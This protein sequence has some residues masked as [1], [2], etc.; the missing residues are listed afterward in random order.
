MR[1]K[2]KR[3]FVLMLVVLIA[4][5]SVI[6]N[7][8]LMTD[9]E[10]VYAAEDSLKEDFEY[11]GG[12]I[13][14]YIGNDAIVKIP[15]GFSKIGDYAF[16]GCDS[17]VAVD[18]PEGVSVL[19]YGAFED[20]SSLNYV[21]IPQS[22]SIMWH[23]AFSGSWNISDIYYGGS[24]DTWSYISIY[25]GTR[26]S[27]L[28]GA[29]RHYNCFEIPE[30]MIKSIGN[31]V[32]IN[33]KTDGKIYTK[34]GYNA[35]VTNDGDLYMW[36][37]YGDYLNLQEGSKRT[38]DLGRPNRVLSNV[39]EFAIGQNTNFFGAL[40]NDND[41]Y[42]WG[43]NWDGELGNGTNDYNLKPHKILSDVK[44]FSLGGTHSAAVTL[45]GDL[46]VWGDNGFCQLG[47]GT[48]ENRYIP[49]KIMENVETVS[50]GIYHS[51]AIKTNG[52]LY[53]WGYNNHGQVGNGEEYNC[54][55]A[56]TKVLEKVKSIDLSDE[57]SCAITK[58][59][60]LYLWG[61]C[62]ESG[63]GSSIKK[64]RKVMDNISYACLSDDWYNACAAINGNGQLFVWDGTTG[65]YNTKDE[66][67]VGTPKKPL[68]DV[69]YVDISNNNILAVGNDGSLFAWGKN[70]DG[71]VGNGTT[72]IQEI[73]IK[74]FQNVRT[75]NIS[76]DACGL[77]TNDNLVYMWGYNKYGN[78]GDGTTINRLEPTL[79]QYAPNQENGNMTDDA[80]T[81]VR[82][83]A[84]KESHFYGAET[85][86]LTKDGE[87]QDAA[88]EFKNELENYLKSFEDEAKK[89]L[90]GEDEIVDLEKL[91]KIL[92]EEDEKTTDRYITMNDSSVPS[93]ALDSVYYTLASF[94]SST[95]NKTV[96]LGDIDFS[97][98]SITNAMK[99]VRAVRSGMSGGK[100]TKKYGDYEVTF[101]TLNMWASF[102]GSVSVTGK[103][104]TYDGVITS[105]VDGT[106]KVLCAYFDELSDIAK[107]AGKY[108]LFSILSEYKDVT[109]ISSFSKE[110]IK[111]FMYD[112]ASAL[113]KN[114]YGDTLSA[115][116]NIHEG[117]LAVKPVI[118]A[119]KGTRLIAAL[120]NSENIYD[121]I[122]DMDFSDKGVKKKAIKKSLNAVE[123]ARKKLEIKLFNKIYDANEEYT[124]EGF[125]DK[126]YNFFGIRCPVDFEVY[127]N[128]GKLI[129]YVDSSDNH[130]EYI[131]YS[132][133]IYIEVLDDVKSLYVPENK[134]VQIKF[135]ATDNG[136]MNYTIER[137]NSGEK[138]GRL[139]YYNVPLKAGGEYLQTIP[140]SVDLNVNKKELVLE[141]GATK[142]VADEF[143]S[144]TDEKAFVTVSVEASEGGIVLGDGQYPKGDSVELNALIEDD[145]YTFEG[146]YNGDVLLSSNEFYRFTAVGDI[147]LTAKFKE[148][149]E[150][151][152]DYN[153][154]Y[155][156]EYS[157]TFVDIFMRNG[158]NEVFI[159]AN[160]SK[161]SKL[162]TIK[163][164]G[165]SSDG[166]NTYTEEKNSISYENGKLFKG[167]DYFKYEKIEIYD[168]S[169]NL[170]VTIE[171][172]DYNKIVQGLL[173]DENELKLKVGDTQQL[174][175]ILVP[176]IAEKK[177]IDW[178]SNDV[179][180]VEVDNVGMLSALKEGATT[181][182]ATLHDDTSIV[183][184]CNVIIEKNSADSDDA[185]SESGDTTGENRGDSDSSNDS[186]KTNPDESQTEY[187]TK[188][189][190][191]PAKVTLKKNSYV[192]DGKSQKPTV[193]VK[194]NNKTL[195]LGKDYNL[196]YKNIKN[197]G[198]ATVTIIGIGNY[199]GNISKNF[200]ISIKDGTNITSDSCKYKIYNDKTATLTSVGENLENVTIPN[201][202]KL[203]NMGFRVRKVAGNVLKDCK[204][205]K[206]IT[207][208]ET[209]IKL[210]KDS[211]TDTSKVAVYILKG[212][213]KYR[214]DKFRLDGTGSVAVN[215]PRDK[216]ISSA[217]IP[218]TVRIAGVKFKITIIS[219]YA[220][221]KCS[222][223]KKVTLGNNVSVL[224]E[225]SFASCKALTKVTIGTNLSKIN[226]SAFNGD[227]SL[228]TI[229]IKSTRLKTVGG[230]SF[231]GINGKAV[232]KVPSSKLKQYKKLLKGKGQGSGVKIV[233]L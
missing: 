203:G 23:G 71:Q 232:I 204:K 60:E 15:S 176:A 42:M 94:L 82:Q 74:I 39:K 54:I 2:K 143:L 217:N 142:L 206:T 158:E 34:S 177:Q 211:F 31:K 213:Y 131:F 132:D 166:T 228:T 21:R 105:T 134:K 231:K 223:L 147:S 136:V 202:I 199:T 172:E 152:G 188:T 95:V 229:S 58:S 179:K 48:N 24:E 170:I 210:E 205:L 163:V 198:T 32:Y 97:K 122:K 53:L 137:V 12:T 79:I 17:L 155:S 128:N 218:S 197:P 106:Q 20:C 224:G 226:K 85:Y 107:D 126:V 173:L 175:A 3:I 77:V 25:S 145:K 149:V 18:I 222:K 84:G 194:L 141:N 101:D 19:G 169:F 56:P 124:E 139:N 78:L 14:K 36:G 103:G 215:S 150:S 221:R 123:K 190:I 153:I 156:E 121:T 180:I 130:D 10:K 109:G 8:Y 9:M 28:E 182:T 186:V 90:G 49:T 181:V 41:L 89:Q 35:T 26:R 113:Q 65:P 189:N 55:S 168:T 33:F 81:T 184:I 225:S 30:N 110:T 216:N 111:D 227:S 207:L 100:Y 108:A 73:P 102:E 167:F 165:Y 171:K 46:Y 118:Q 154:T 91:G 83:I 157:D 117:Y 183:A 76:D 146:W 62:F 67:D 148:K 230:S 193:T 120:K 220:F 37:Y 104:K 38:L 63:N 233:K 51:G 61:N 174:N 70:E 44:T 144:G 191:A 114:G 5:Q 164:K 86:G 57:N 4:L 195:T 99:I 135:I 75:V 138:I 127:D 50:L 68:K 59:G 6:E 192:Y 129:G 185:G 151:L 11:S 159:R 212:A 208:P 96:D 87:I 52:D 27:G 16:K 187:A 29:T 200:K 214:F 1:C 219:K 22:M 115:F 45:D 40:T 64:P 133:G 98:D 47:D 201:T 43:G 80:I 160:S 209:V 66:T 88:I 92:R 178:K 162:G 7:D 119:T 93:S 116:V 125:W 140:A 69:K 72:E 161:D 196:S 13:T 112:K